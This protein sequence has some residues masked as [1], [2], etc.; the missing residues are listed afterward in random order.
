[1]HFGNRLRAWRHDRGLTLGGLSLRSGVSKS[2]L[3]RWE[4][5][6]K[7]GAT[8]TPRANELVRVLDALKVPAEQKAAAL[9]EFGHVSAL[10]TL[11]RGAGLEFA[12]PAAGRLGGGTPLAIVAPLPPRPCAT[13][14]PLPPEVPGGTDTLAGLPAGGES[15]AGVVVL[16][17]RVIRDLRRRHGWTQSALAAALG[18]RQGTVSK[19]ESGDDWPDAARRVALCRLLCTAHPPRGCV[20]QG[21]PLV[22]LERSSDD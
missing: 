3:S 18:V 13:F 8:I 1:V 12:A 15:A 2:T 14:R 22:I 7:S 5:S 17:G 10:A 20:L 19:W 9:A 4:A 21:G 16:V 6:A 11:A